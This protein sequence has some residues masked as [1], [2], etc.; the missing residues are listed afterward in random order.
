MGKFVNR[1]DGNNQQI[2]AQGALDG[3]S[4]RTS[5]VARLCPSLQSQKFTQ[6][7]LFAA[8]VLKEFLQFDYRK[9]S[10]FFLDAPEFRAAIELHKVPHF[11][12]FQKAAGRLL[13]Y[14]R[15]RRLLRKTIRIAVNRRRIR[16]RVALAALDGTGLESHHAS[17]Y[18]VRRCAAGG[19]TWQKA[20]VALI[21]AVIPEA[22]LRAFLQR[23]EVSNAGGIPF[24]IQVGIVV[25]SQAFL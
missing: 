20:I 16:R 13:A 4:G 3:L 15:A 21:C 6:P 25:H 24:P 9:L 8:P 18:Y 17:T 19:K 10:Q 23:G 1:M 5:N 2:A 12:T 11:T 14:P 22:I 7:Q